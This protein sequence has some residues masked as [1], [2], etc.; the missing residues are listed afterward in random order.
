MFGTVYPFCYYLFAWKCSIISLTKNET[1]VPTETIKLS[2]SNNASPKNDRVIGIW[3]YKWEKT[4]FSDPTNNIINKEIKAKDAA[5]KIDVE[6]NTNNKYETVIDDK[7]DLSEDD[8]LPDIGIAVSD[9]RSNQEIEEYPISSSYSS[10]SSK[11]KGFD[12]EKSSQITFSQK[13][14]DLNLNSD[15]NTFGLSEAFSAAKLNIQ[16]TAKSPNPIAKFSPN[17]FDIILF[18]DNCEQSHA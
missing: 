11:T 14:T 13:S 2:I 8:E 10:L 12:S 9:Y 15:S 5:F 18:V 17:T 7:L 1:N 16:Q 3:L 4:S 6:K